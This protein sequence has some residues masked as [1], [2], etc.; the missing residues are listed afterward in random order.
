MHEV[1]EIKTVL[2]HDLIKGSSILHIF[3]EI[4][5]NN[6][7]YFIKDSAAVSTFCWISQDIS[8]SVF[9]LLFWFC[10]SLNWK[11]KLF[12]FLYK[13]YL[14]FEENMVQNFGMEAEIQ[15]KSVNSFNYAICIMYTHCYRNC[16]VFLGA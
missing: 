8:V 11:K 7:H 12:L 3:K 1:C 10:C 15:A 5:Q 6:Y 2:I 13:N 4:W 14:R 9:Y 16:F